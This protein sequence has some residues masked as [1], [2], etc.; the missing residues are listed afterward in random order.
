MFQ[1]LLRVGHSRKNCVQGECR[2]CAEI[3]HT[4]L[5]GEDNEITKQS[6]NCSVEPKSLTAYCS[7]TIVRNQILLPTSVFKIQNTVDDC[8]NEYSFVNAGLNHA[9]E[10]SW[11]TDEQ[12]NHNS[13]RH[14]QE[15]V[16]RDKVGISSNDKITS[17]SESRTQ[18]EKLN[19]KTTVYE[20]HIEFVSEH[21]IFGQI[22]SLDVSAAVVQQYSFSLL[23]SFSFRCQR[24]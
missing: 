15:I 22:F 19:R 23:Y 9:K 8:M 7:T 6:G 5:H 18:A 21:I 16:S 11:E 4:L 20:Q 17:L 3:H 10:L 12:V 1:L 13:N 24:N 14:F 2:K